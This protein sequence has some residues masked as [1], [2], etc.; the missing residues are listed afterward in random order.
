MNIIET[1]NALPLADRAEAAHQA[2]KRDGNLAFGLYH[3]N[4]FEGSMNS[5][6]HADETVALFVDHH[7]AQRSMYS[8]YLCDDDGNEVLIKQY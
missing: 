6:V 2:A 4:D 1:L 3:D 7:G 5:V 8:L